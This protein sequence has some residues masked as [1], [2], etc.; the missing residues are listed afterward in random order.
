MIGTVTTVSQTLVVRLRLT[1]ATTRPKVAPI[2][3]REHVADKAPG[4]GDP[5]LE[6]VQPPQHILSAQGV[7]RGVQDSIDLTRELRPACVRAALEDL[8]RVR[9]QGGGTCRIGN[10]DRRRGIWHVPIEPHRVPL[11]QPISRT[12]HGARR[13]TRSANELFCRRLRPD[14]SRQRP[15]FGPCPPWPGYS[16]LG[17]AP[18]RLRLGRRSRRGRQ[19]TG[20]MGTRRVPGWP[21][22]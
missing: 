16:G 15:Q 18:L 3:P 12:A 1:K 11:Q 7:G 4:C 13:L 22:N 9:H 21:R 8:E 10:W 6:E 14:N 17:L 19:L 20:G 5:E 2:A